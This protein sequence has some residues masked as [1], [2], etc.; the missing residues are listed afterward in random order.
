MTSIRDRLNTDAS[1]DLRVIFPPAID[2]V[3][4]LVVSKLQVVGGF[5]FS[6]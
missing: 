1:I 2:A 6:H 4:S 3:T 5:N